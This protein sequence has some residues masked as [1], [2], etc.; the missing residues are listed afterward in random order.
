MTRTVNRPHRICGRPPKLTPEQ[1]QRVHAWAEFGTTKTEV[2][3]RLGIN[4]KTLNGYI[5][6]RLKAP[7]RDAS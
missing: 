5:N 2:A 6:G 1:Q 4:N 3:R 7:I